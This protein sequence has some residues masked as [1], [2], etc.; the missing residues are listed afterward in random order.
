MSHR[1]QV[2]IPEGLDSR[3]AKAAQRAS[4]SK[5][6][7]VRRALEQALSAAQSGPEAGFA[8]IPGIRRVPLA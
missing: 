7:W 1:L 4:L 6:E 3:L 8:R 2:L 5:G